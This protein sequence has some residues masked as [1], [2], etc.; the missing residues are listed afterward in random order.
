M[1]KVIHS[2]SVYLISEPRVDLVV[3]DAYLNDTGHAAIQNTSHEPS[4]DAVVSRQ[5]GELL[6]ETGGRVCYDSFTNKRP[7]GSKAY[8]DRIKSEGHGSVF[9]HANYTFLI[10]G[11]SRTLSHELVRH[12]AGWA[13]SQQSQRYVNES[14][15]AFVLPIDI[16]PQSEEY[17]IWYESCNKSLIEYKELV[18]SLYNKFSLRSKSGI[19]AQDPQSQ[20][21]IEQKTVIRKRARQAARSVL[22]GCT[23]T[24]IQ[25]TA[26]VRAIRHFIEMRASRHAEPE[27]RRLANSV[28]TIMRHVA[29][30]LFDDYVTCLL[31]DGT[32]EITTEYKK[33]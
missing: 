16:Q 14:D 13:Y 24:R 9:E 28:Y 7:G 25:A 2:P 29:S 31:D 23:E 22:P 30:Y 12:R 20:E 33:V 3:L 4:A 6:I 1:I 19:Y 11:I 10:R 21:A 32:L 17:Y 18:E 15:C 27:I 5:S 26:N 8:F